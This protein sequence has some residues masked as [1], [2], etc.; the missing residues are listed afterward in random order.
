MSELLKILDLAGPSDFQN[1]AKRISLETQELKKYLHW[2]SRGYTRNCIRR[3]EN[4][5]LIALC[6]EAGHETP[7]HCHGGEECWVYMV[8]GELEESRFEE[9]NFNHKI[10]SVCMELG[11]AQISYMEDSNGFHCLENKKSTR[12]VSLHLYHKPISRCRIFDHEN[13]DFK[14]VEMKDY[15]FEGRLL[16]ES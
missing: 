6:W 7:I 14:W 16:Q 4:Y 5:E 13:Q 8:Q 12:A 10:G 1:L 11:K 2:S 15:S 3:T 9:E